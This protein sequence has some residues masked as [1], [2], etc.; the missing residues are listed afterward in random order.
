MNQA[1]R[2]FAA[3][4]AA[5]IRRESFRRVNALEQSSES[6]REQYNKNA[7]PFVWTAS[8]ELILKKVEKVC[9]RTSNSGH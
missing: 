5:Q 3:I 9:K 7:K 6:Y 1:E 4:A 2:F 8:A